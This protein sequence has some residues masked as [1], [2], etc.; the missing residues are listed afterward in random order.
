MAAFPRRLSI[1]AHPRLSAEHPDEQRRRCS[2]NGEHEAT[3]SVLVRAAPRG[4]VC[5]NALFDSV[6]TPQSLAPNRPSTTKLGGRRLRHPPASAAS[7]A[8]PSCASP[9]S[10]P[11][12]WPRPRQPGFATLPRPLACTRRSCDELEARQCRRSTMCHPARCRLPGCTRRPATPG[13]ATSGPS[14]APDAP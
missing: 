7:R 8:Q 2:P 5:S 13:T 1:T 4:A 11:F 9:A 10:R 3:P 6:P 14:P 12:R